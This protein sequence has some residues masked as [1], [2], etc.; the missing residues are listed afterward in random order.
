[1]ELPI[2]AN[3]EEAQQLVYKRE[4]L[5]QLAWDNLA[6][7]KIIAYLG[8]F[9]FVLLLG[10]DSY[11]YY[12]GIYK[13]NPYVSYAIFG[14]FLLALVLLPAFMYFKNKT[15]IQNRSY[16]NKEFITN[17][18]IFVISLALIEMGLIGVIL[19]G[20]ITPYAILILI[21]NLIYT[22]PRK[23]SIVVN[24]L[25]FLIMIT[26]IMLIQVN[27]LE[28][29]IVNAIECTA[30]TLPSFLVSNLQYDLKYK[31]FLSEKKIKEQQLIIEASLVS[32]FNKKI[33]EMEMSV[34]RA[35]MNPHFLFNC[36]NSIKLYM[37]QNDARTAASYLTKFS[38]L[39]RLILNNSKSKEVKLSHEL[40]A[41][42]LYIEMEQFRFRNKFDFQIII[43][44]V[45]G[46]EFIDI[47]PMILQ[48]FVENAIWHGL[49][50]KENGKGL[51][52]IEVKKLDNNIQFVIQDNG[53]GREK[54]AAIKPKS[55]KDHK[56]FGIQI[57][58]DR[59]AF[60]NQF[61]NINATLQ[62]IDLK[63]ED[64]NARGTKVVIL[65]PILN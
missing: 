8:C 32:E 27:D 3:K 10:L 18:T 20:M 14:H 60:T 5:E 53:I 1:M 31:Q 17:L 11:R 62:I 39:I 33:A 23:I 38:R 54:A 29:L 59:I 16:K 64:G 48:P 2:S 15:A 49:M 6:K 52:K 41:L 21:L 7:T 34:L 43:D 51:L 42:K 37:V 56:S 24:A 19:R 65:L 58:K 4:F 25:G 13:S 26:G 50:H 45:I 44:K 36:L 47:P 61:Y 30:F 9:F 40:E 35:Q 28:S 22:L 46:A 55:R 12:F 57:T 63:D